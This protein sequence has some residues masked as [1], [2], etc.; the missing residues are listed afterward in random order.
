MCVDEFSVQKLRECLE[1]IQKLTSQIQD[2]QERVNCMNDLGEFPNVES[3]YSGK[4]FSRS[5]STSNRSNSSICVK[6][7]Q[8][9]AI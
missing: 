3:N 1:A 8:M 6:P 7:R 5:Q 4:N 2:L 9:H